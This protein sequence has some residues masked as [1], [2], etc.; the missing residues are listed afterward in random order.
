METLQYEF[1]PKTTVYYVARTLFTEDNPPS[2]SVYE[3]W[4]GEVRIT[5]DSCDG[6]VRTKYYVISLMR[7][8]SRSFME[9]D[10]DL[11]ETQKDAQKRADFLN[12]IEEIDIKCN[13][14]RR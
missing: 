12:Q 2:Y 13:N 7:G 5:I 4:I 14:L 1:K 10:L 11:C 6:I 8:E 3:G 9:G